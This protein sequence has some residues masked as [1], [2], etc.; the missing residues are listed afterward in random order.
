MVSEDAQERCLL[1]VCG[2]VRF[3]ERLSAKLQAKAIAD[4]IDDHPE[5]L[6]LAYVH[7]KFKENG[8]LGIRSEA[9]KMAML[10]AL[11]LVECIAEGTPQGTK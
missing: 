5:K 6:L 2:R 10:A 9:E 11:N 4:A 7:G 8:L 3:I 1:R